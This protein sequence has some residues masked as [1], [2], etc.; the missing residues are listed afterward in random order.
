MV[1]RHL[2][3]DV[4]VLAEAELKR[5]ESYSVYTVHSL[6]SR[7]TEGNNIAGLCQALGCDDARCEELEHILRQYLKQH[8]PY[9]LIPKPRPEKGKGALNPHER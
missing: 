8:D 1:D 7:I 2:L 5:L 9:F 4:G 6:Y 3:R